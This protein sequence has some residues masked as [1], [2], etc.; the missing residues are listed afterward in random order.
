MTQAK[1]YSI[2]ARGARAAEVFIYGDI[3]ESW[4]GESVTAAEFVKEIAALDVDELTVRINS[5][6]GSVTD[7]LAMYN[8]L[9]RHKASVTISIDGIAASI[10]SLVAMAGD[11]VEMAENA[12]L[13]VHA[14][15][16]GAFGNSADLREFADVLDKH[17]QAMSSS[18]AA[19]TGRPQ[20]EMLALLTD[21]QDHWLGADEALA[22][23]F[24]D[25]VTDAIP[26]A[27]HMDL[28]RFRSIPAAAAAF[29]S[30]TTGMPK[31]QTT[32][33]APEPLAVTD[34]QAPAPVAEPVT[35]ATP[36]VAEIEARVLAADARRRT[37]IA[38]R[39]EHFAGRDGVAELLAACQ[40]DPRVSVAD[41][42]ERLLAHLAKD[43]G[44]IGGSY[45]VTI[46]DERDK[47]RTAATEAI[48]ARAAARDAEGRP[49]RIG[50]ENPLRGC[51]AVDLARE[52][53]VRAGVRVDGMSRM[54]LVAAAF[55]QS[56][57]DFPVLLENTMHKVLLQAY[58]VAPDTW[59]RFCKIGSVS[60][61]RAHSRY[62]LGS[63]GSLDS[64]NELGEYQNKSIPDGQRTTIIAKTKG[65]I[66]NVSRQM[67]ID[68]DLRALRDL[69]DGLG[70][71]AKLSVEK[72]VYALIALNSGMGPD[73]A[74]TKPLFHSDHG[75]VASDGVMSVTSIDDAR[76]KMASQMDISGN[77]YLDLRPAV[78]LC[79]TA[80]GGTARV[81]NAAEY[82]P[83]TANK[84]QMP[85]MVR[86]LF[87]DVV[88][89]ARLSGAR[90]YMFA[91]PNDAPVF[92]VAF[93][94]GVQEPYLELQ[95]GFDVDGGRYKVRLDYGVAALDYRGAV[96]G[97]GSA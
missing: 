38:A 55:T 35:S 84:L 91:D 13:M 72:D 20:D 29:T 71:A 23:G 49:M 95:D 64:L 66:I 81:L 90:F 22:E 19:K 76:A 75:N 8:A 40:N 34:S 5:Y 46:E 68:D 96:T 32:G 77:D 79:S 82:D 30:R 87:R 14:P 70:R 36:D 12:L 44:P 86:G 11:T 41:A 9:K 65:N 2:R 62:R 33:G 73:M 10:A 59:S 1:W 50:A 63:F 85:N 57:S 24:V 45:V 37:D 17:A 74:D 51:S 52:C 18:Y 25:V 53:L 7:G 69:A 4:W 80:S 89:T 93:L 60:D 28:S 58:A 78:L 88:D 39:F 43:V 92:E 67:I 56:T 48:L 3:G 42:G 21:G 16:G 6:G 83:S 61:F 47:F 97:K 31:Q 54:E 26:I 15:W 27:A 94:D